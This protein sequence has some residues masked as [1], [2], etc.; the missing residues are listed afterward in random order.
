ML[1]SLSLEGTRESKVLG[2]NWSW[3]YCGGT[4]WQSCCCGSARRWLV[5]TTGQTRR[6][7]ARPRVVVRVRGARAGGWWRAGRCA[8]VSFQILRGRHEGTSEGAMAWRPPSCGAG[9]LHSRSR[10]CLVLARKRASSQYNALSHFPWHIACN[11]I[12][13]GKGLWSNRVS[14]NSRW[15]HSAAVLAAG[16][17]TPRG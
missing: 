6:C 17:S 5:E 11:P 4:P 15:L 10:A 8:C 14:A 3:N 1:P 9:A 16:C 12:T 7:E 2:W 13:R